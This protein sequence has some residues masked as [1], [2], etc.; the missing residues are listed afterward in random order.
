[1]LRYDAMISKAI[2]IHTAPHPR[3]AYALDVLSGRQQWSGADLRGN[4]KKYGA[5][6]AIQRRLAERSLAEAGG[7][8]IYADN[9]ERV[10]AVLVGQDDMGNALYE[11][12]EGIRIP[13]PKQGRFAHRCV[14]V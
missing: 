14:A 12:A 4:A 13:S 3:A 1:M 5:G 2:E 10:S 8:T 6:Y 7:E 11:T 9:G